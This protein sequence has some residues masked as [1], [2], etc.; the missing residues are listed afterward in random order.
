MTR[1][2][3]SR[4]GG[5]GSPRR[6]APATAAASAAAPATAASAAASGT[7]SGTASGAALPTVS[8]SGRSATS[9][10]TGSYTVRSTGAGTRMPLSPRET[11]QSLTVVGRQQMDERGIGAVQMPPPRH[12]NPTKR[13]RQPGQPH[14]M[15]HRRGGAWRAGRGGGRVGHA[16]MALA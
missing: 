14:A 15:R 16:A 2:S 6:R 7:T 13:P 5:S 10:G 9:E 1:A 11:P 4:R 3:S 8:V 12:R